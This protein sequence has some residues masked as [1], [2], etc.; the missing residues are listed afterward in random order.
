MLPPVE[1]SVRPPAGR[2]LVREAGPVQAIVTGTPRELLKLSAAPMRF[3]RVL[4]DTTVGAEVQLEVRP[5]DLELPRGVDVHVQDVP[6]RT[7]AGQAGLN[8]PPVRP[9]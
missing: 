7:V 5:G 3:T 6:P 4:P 8:L 1:V 2:T 9:P